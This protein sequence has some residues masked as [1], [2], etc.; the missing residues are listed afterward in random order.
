M[1][2]LLVLDHQLR[3][4]DL[5]I[6]R[7]DV[8]DIK[9]FIRQVAMEVAVDSFA[10]LGIES[11]LLEKLCNMFSSEVVMDLDD[12]IVEEIAAEQQDSKNERART[13][14]KLQRLETGLQTM[15]RIGRHNLGGKYIF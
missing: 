10:I 12:E 1:K 7:R 2:Y 5:E 8:S 14:T 11:C 4:N 15:R 6:H 3:S 9:N 13:L